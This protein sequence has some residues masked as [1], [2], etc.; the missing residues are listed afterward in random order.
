MTNEIIL[1]N[2]VYFYRVVYSSNTAGDPT[3]SRLV[4]YILCTHWLSG[5]GWNQS[6][7]RVLLYSHLILDIEYGRDKPNCLA[8]TTIGRDVI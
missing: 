1:K 3:A 2:V 6:F 5:R 8:W 4:L 7:H